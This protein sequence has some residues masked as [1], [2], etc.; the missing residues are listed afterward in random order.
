MCIQVAGLQARKKQQKEEVGEN[1][2]F[3]CPS[4]KSKCG[5]D[6]CRSME[7]PC[8]WSEVRLSPDRD[9]PH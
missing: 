7:V 6:T 9:G 8:S 2:L 5:A 1:N 3:V 4:V